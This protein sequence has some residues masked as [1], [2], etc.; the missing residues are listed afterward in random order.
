MATLEVSAS[1]FSSAKSRR[2][3]AFH[4]N[5]SSLNLPV[6]PPSFRPLRR[7][8]HFRTPLTRELCLGQ[9]FR[10]R[11][12]RSV[13]EIDAEAPAAGIPDE[14]DQQEPKRKL[15]VVNLPWSVSTDDLRTL[16]GQCGTIEDV[17]IMRTRSGQSRGFGFVTMAAVEDAQAVIDKFNSFDLS[18]RIIRV[19]FARKFMK[20]VAPPP[21]PSLPPTDPSIGETIHK[22]Y[23]SNLAWKVRSMHL[24]DLFSEKFK[25]IS[26]RVVF[27]TP[28]GR[29]AGYGF[30]SFATKEE[31]EAALS[32]FDGREL[33]GRPLRLKFSVRTETLSEKEEG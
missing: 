32:E 3:L 13:Q 11:P 2:V 26:S 17:E 27:E 24:R 1:F 6:T 9:S 30:V 20:P 31:A 22:L 16:F 25:P 7:A 14:G 23:V 10:F 33:M 12:C 18:G 5:P 8:V 28:P 29:S 21:P 15:Y 4:L 19:E